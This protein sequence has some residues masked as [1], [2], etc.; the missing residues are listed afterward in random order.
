MGVLKKKY[1]EEQEVKK[2]IEVSY[3]PFLLVVL[4]II[5]NVKMSIILQDKVREKDLALRKSIR[6]NEA[7]DLRNTQV[8][9]HVFPS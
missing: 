5:V 9:W 1:L 6:E 7:L 4:M 3:E 2:A 8:N